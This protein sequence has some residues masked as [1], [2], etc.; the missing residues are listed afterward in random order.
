V[1]VFDVSSDLP[2]YGKKGRGDSCPDAIHQLTGNI[3]HLEVQQQQH[4]RSRPSQKPQPGWLVFT[5]GGLHVRHTVTVIPGPCP[6]VIEAV[7]TAARPGVTESDVFRWIGVVVAVAGVVLATPDGI[8][9]AWLSVKD[10]RR[11]AL[12]RGRRLLR[13]SGRVINATATLTGTGTMTGRAHGYAWQPWRENAWVYEKIDILHKQIDLLLK[14][15]NDLRSLVDRTGDDF[16][17]EI[18]QAENRITDQIGQLAAEMRGER[19][20]SGPIALG[21]ILTG[22]PD[23]LAATAYGWLGWLTVAVAVIWIACVVPSWQRDYRQALKN[24]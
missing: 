11:R 16:R 5:T 24:S 10:W 3:K 22:L 2:K 21:I 9:S 4:S 18:R 1:R 8:A 15:V 19:T 20:R 6:V 12:A 14:Q 23:E 17:K 13:L 7:R